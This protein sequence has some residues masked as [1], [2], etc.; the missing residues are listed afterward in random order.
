[1]RWRNGSVLALVVIGLVAG[2]VG[3][4]NDTVDD[5]D[6]P[7][8]VL[9]VESFDSPAVTAT[10]QGS[11]GSGGVTACLLQAA[12]WQMTLRNVPKTDLAGPDSSPFNDI[13]LDTMTVTYVWGGLPAGTVVPTSGVI[14]LGGITIEPE[15]T[16]SI[17]FS[18]IG[19]NV[20]ATDTGGDGEPDLA[21]TSAL[22]NMVIRAHTV[23]N[24]QIT[25]PLTS[26]LNVQICPPSNSP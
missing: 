14:G 26:V 18:P 13:I 1:M 22:V 12:D 17:T 2:A 4:T 20:L 23:E 25:L 21:G 15:D 3:C 7:D 16:G 10:L 5:G 11:G 9:E 24:E 19:A 8:V 6:S